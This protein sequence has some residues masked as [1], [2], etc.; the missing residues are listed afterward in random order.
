MNA[1]RNCGGFSTANVRDGI[2]A[3]YL[4]VSI[5]RDSRCVLNALAAM[6]GLDR[7]THVFSTE[8]A[9]LDARMYENELLGAVREMYTVE[10]SSKILN[11]MNDAE[12]RMIMAGACR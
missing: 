9:L 2:V 5:D 8:G 4:Y 3:A 7:R 12:M 6:F 10:V 1:G 11:G